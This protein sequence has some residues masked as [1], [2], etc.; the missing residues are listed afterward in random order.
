MRD[1]FNFESQSTRTVLGIDY[2]TL[3]E[4]STAS[5]YNEEPHKK[6]QQKPISEEQKNMYRRIVEEFNE[7]MKSEI[8]SLHK[9]GYTL[10]VLQ[11]ADGIAKCEFY[12]RKIPFYSQEL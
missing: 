4:E 3:N 12:N 6:P 2:P 9:R 10:K 7:K 1:P 11:I 8:T 5:T